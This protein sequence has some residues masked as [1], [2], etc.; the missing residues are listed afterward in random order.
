V[1]NVH[2]IFYFWNPADSSWAGD[3]QL[4]MDEFKTLCEEIDKGAR[5]VQ[6]HCMHVHNA[7]TY[8]TCTHTRSALL[9]RYG[10]KLSQ[11][12]THLAATRHCAVCRTGDALSNFKTA[13]PK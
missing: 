4:S 1:C 9:W 7:L 8:K 2:I 3:G 12:F 11:F 13:N 10:D 5:E 6:L